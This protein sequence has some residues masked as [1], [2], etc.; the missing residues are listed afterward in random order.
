MVK[1]SKVA[2]RD[3]FDDRIAGF[4]REGEHLSKTVLG[5]AEFGLVS[6]MLRDGYAKSS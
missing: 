5:L 2:E 1:V 4:R 3:R 6:S